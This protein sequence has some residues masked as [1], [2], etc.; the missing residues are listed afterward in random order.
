VARQRG[1]GEQAGRQASRLAGKKAR[2]K[3]A[4]LLPCLHPPARL[5]HSTA[6]RPYAAGDKELIV[7]T[8]LVA[9]DG[10][11]K[12]PQ[13]S[14]ASRGAPVLPLTGLLCQLLREL[15]C[16]GCPAQALWP[17]HS[18]QLSVGQSTLPHWA[19]PAHAHSQPSCPATL[20]GPPP[21][22]SACCR[23]LLARSSSRRCRSWGPA[24]GRWA[25]L[26]VGWLVG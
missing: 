21:L 22:P 17:T 15:C 3:T 4:A 12:L 8:L 16:A 1:E 2:I 5:C 11:F 19:H 9:A 24:G 13:A 14:V 20:I 23:S 6:C 25:C 26:G 18:A 7:V 10:G